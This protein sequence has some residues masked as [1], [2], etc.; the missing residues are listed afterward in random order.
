MYS[1]VEFYGY[2][3]AA[4]EDVGDIFFSSYS[5]PNQEK[6]ESWDSSE[7]FHHC[8]DTDYWDTN[9]DWVIAVYTLT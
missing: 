9:R 2:W 3:S 5:K 8:K 1:P 6:R 4:W 7:W